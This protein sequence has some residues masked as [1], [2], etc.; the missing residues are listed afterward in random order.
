MKGDGESELDAVKDFDAH[1]GV[2][3][4]SGSDRMGCDDRSEPES[5]P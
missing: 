4:P 1:L 2:L 5:P 3:I